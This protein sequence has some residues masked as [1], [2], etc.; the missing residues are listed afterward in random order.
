LKFDELKIVIEYDGFKEHFIDREEVNESNYL[1]YMKDDD[2]YR[3]KV[4]EGY[5]Y[6]FLRINRFNIGDDPVETLDY[7]LQNLLKKNLKIS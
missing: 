2:I 1:H 6:K 3:Q 7:R 5:G 4:L